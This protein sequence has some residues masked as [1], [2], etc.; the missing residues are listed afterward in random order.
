MDM[1]IEIRIDWTA[2]Q[3]RRFLGQADITPI[4]ELISVMADRAAFAAVE[5]HLE[6]LTAVTG[7]MN[8][9]DG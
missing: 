6:A 2:N 5:R 8:S 1:A 7:G 9:D 3:W 4:V